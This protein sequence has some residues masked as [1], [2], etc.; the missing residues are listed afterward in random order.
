M[1]QTTRD[2][3]FSRILE[4]VESIHRLTP[5]QARAILHTIPDECRLTSDAA[6]EA[7]TGRRVQEVD[8][9]TAALLVNARQVGRSPDVLLELQAD[10]VGLHLPA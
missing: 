8:R 4:L 6:L 5:A 10:I 3:L 7:L 2:P 1:T 9:L